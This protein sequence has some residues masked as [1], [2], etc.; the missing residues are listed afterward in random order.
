MRPFPPRPSHR[1]I[2]TALLILTLLALPACQST[3]RDRYYRARG[4]SFFPVTAA[5]ATP[6][7]T[8]S[9]DAEP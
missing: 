6:V 5:S 3:T 4:A 8:A 1:A 9:V 2:P 7:R